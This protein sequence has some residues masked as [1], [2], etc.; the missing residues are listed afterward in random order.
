MQRYNWLGSK[1]LLLGFSVR[2]CLDS[3]PDFGFGG[4]GFSLQ[5]T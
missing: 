5:F 1:N 3:G 4:S 2:A